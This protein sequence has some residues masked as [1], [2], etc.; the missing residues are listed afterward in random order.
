M[1]RDAGKAMLQSSNFLSISA[2][3]LDEVK[4]VTWRQLWNVLQSNVCL[5]PILVCA[6]LHR[7]ILKRNFVSR[8]SGLKIENSGSRPQNLLIACCK[9]MKRNFN[10]LTLSFVV[11][12][13]RN[14]AS[15]DTQL[16]VHVSGRDAVDTNT[17]SNNWIAEELGHKVPESSTRN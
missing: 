15:R 11:K 8:N 6:I 13:F 4:N 3:R 7:K 10:L 5:I 17:E 16:I 1:H 12:Q 9:T 14:M 2:I